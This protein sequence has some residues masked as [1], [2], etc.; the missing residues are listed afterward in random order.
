MNVTYF[1]KYKQTDK[2]KNSSE[3]Q[4]EVLIEGEGGMGEYIPE[5]VKI[6]RKVSKSASTRLVAMGTPIVLLFLF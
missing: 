3:N 5:P 1:V 6:K 4:I 2:F